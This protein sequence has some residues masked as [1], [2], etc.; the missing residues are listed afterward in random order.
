MLKQAKVYF[1]TAAKLKKKIKEHL[2][3]GPRP[4]PNVSILPTVY[5]LASRYHSN[6]EGKEFFSFLYVGL[7]E[8]C[9]ANSVPRATLPPPPP[10][11]K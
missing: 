3:L 7:G 2:S 11:C 8:L 10:V 1:K 6:E 5:F 4:M 9:A